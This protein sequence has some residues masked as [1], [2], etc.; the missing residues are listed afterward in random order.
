MSNVAVEAMGII[1]AG[2]A[3]RADEKAKNPPKKG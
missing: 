1:G 3:W 2:I